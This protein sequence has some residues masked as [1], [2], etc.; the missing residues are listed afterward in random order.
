MTWTVLVALA[1]DLVLLAAFWRVLT[2]R[3]AP[4]PTALDIE[5]VPV[6]VDEAELARAAAELYRI[7]RR[8]DV[9]WTSHQLRNDA[10]RLQRELDEEMH[11]VEVLEALDRA[12]G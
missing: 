8:F 2:R 7:S 5:T 11:R 9:A 4:A 3:S 10:L 1:I 6:D 12:D